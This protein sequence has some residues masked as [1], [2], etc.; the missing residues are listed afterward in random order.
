MSIKDSRPPTTKVSILIADDH[1]ILLDGMIAML[2]KQTKIEVKGIATD[3]Q[4]ALDLLIQNDYDVC[5]LDINMPKLD[6]LDVV[7]EI[8]KKKPSTK[9]LVITTYTDKEIIAEMLKLKVAGYILKNCSRE[10]LVKAIIDV[11]DGEC[12]YSDEVYDTA[13]ANFAAT[14]NDAP[15]AE[16][17]VLTKRETEIVKLLSM[18]YT[19]D[20]IADELGISYRTVETHRKNIMQKTQSHNLAGLLKFAF[21]KGII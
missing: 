20:K 10:Q 21:S 11:A 19:N 13:I 2:K 8:K 16:E 18:E 5:L 14:P 1:R 12:Y 17:I 15:T 3:G 7:R 9:I 6:G 4:Q